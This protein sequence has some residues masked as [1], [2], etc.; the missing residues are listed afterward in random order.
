[1]DN[2]NSLGNAQAQ[3]I[4][5]DN[6]SKVDGGNGVGNSRQNFDDSVDWFS[7]LSSGSTQPIGVHSK[8]DSDLGV[9]G[10]VDQIL[11]NI[12]QNG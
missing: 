3:G 7:A 2:I 6:L 5:H 9:N 4:G 8:H 1:M 12:A 10:M 11:S